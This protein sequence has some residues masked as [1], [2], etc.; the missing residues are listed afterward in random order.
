MKKLPYTI[1]KYRD[2]K[3]WLKARGV[4]GSD[5]CAVVNGVGRWGTIVGVWEELVYGIQG[6]LIENQ[7]MTDGRRAEEPIKELFLIRHP[8]L[9]RLSPSKAIWL[10]RR[11]DTPE[12]TLSPD[13]LV[14]RGKE[15][16]F[17][18]IKLKTIHNESV[19]PNYLVNLKEE[20][21]Q[22]Y[23]QIIHYFVAKPDTAFGYFVVCFDLQKKEEDGA[24][25]HQRYLIDELYISRQDVLEDIERAEKALQD[26][27]VNSLRPKKRPEIKLEGRKETQI[28][29]DKSS[30]IK[31]LR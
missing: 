22:Y 12:I 5:L 23:W 26:F 24:W 14:K 3:S 1:E 16:G 7:S 10:V 15:Q 25:R 6:T 31:T 4:G 28:Q 30:N 13:T 29:W 2:R 21:P 27:I 20:E 9:E 18:E 11:N 17:A 8:E 19:I